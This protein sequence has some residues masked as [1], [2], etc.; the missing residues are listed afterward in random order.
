M[1]IKKIITS[2]LIGALL[3]PTNIVGATE[4]MPNTSLSD[5]DK[6]SSCKVT[7][8]INYSYYVS[9]P[10]SLILEVTETTDVYESKYKVKAK[11]KSE[12]LLGKHIKI[13]PD[14]IADL[15]NESNGDTVA[16]HI[17][18]DKKYFGAK[19]TDKQEKI[20]ADKW[21]EINGVVKANIPNSGSYKGNFKFEYGLVD[22]IEGTPLSEMTFTQIQSI[23]RAGKTNEYD[24]NIGDTIKVNDSVDAEIIAIGS[25]YIEFTTMQ[26]VVDA[27]GSPD[28]VS[29]GRINVK[30]NAVS[31]F[32]AGPQVNNGTTNATQVGYVGSN[33]QSQVNA[34]LDAQSDEF[35][36]SLQDIEREYEVATLSFDD[37]KYSQAI[38]GTVKDIEKVY[39][40]TKT[41]LNRVYQYVTALRNTYFW[42]ATPYAAS[43][44]TADAGRSF[45]I[46]Y[47]GISGA[48]GKGNGSSNNG[49]IVLFRIG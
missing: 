42:T 14:S 46:F 27:S 34:W 32:Y 30:Y 15:V 35:K 10:A 12:G 47:F 7:A 43:D 9:M 36:A 45:G 41:E 2:L 21:T 23:A 26:K 8:D 6:T 17:N 22:V 11:T 1:Q 49:A 3:V 25:D 40:P 44:Y 39:I 28:S 20:D 5:T 16:L 29:V 13:A 33:I 4:N 37:S 19:K 18:Q 38:T 31:S 24:I 48:I